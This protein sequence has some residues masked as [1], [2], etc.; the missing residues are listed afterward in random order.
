MVGD[1]PKQATYYP[2]R[3]WTGF[4]HKTGNSLLRFFEN[5]IIHAPAIVPTALVSAWD[6]WL[7]GGATDAELRRGL[8]ELFK[9]L[10]TIARGKPSGMFWKNV[11][12]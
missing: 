5:D 3:G 10:D 1:F 4:R 2:K 7:E 11:F 6:K 8:A 9:W 12:F